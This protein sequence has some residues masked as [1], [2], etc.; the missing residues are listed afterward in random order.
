VSGPLAGI[1]VLEFAGIGPGPFA[2]MLLADLGADVVRLER[3][4]STMAAGREPR[5]DV[6]QRGKRS[7]GLDLRQPAGV[8]LALELV[9]TADAVIE[10]FR[11]GVMERL[12]VGP[13]ECLA[14]NP[15]LIFGRMTGWGQTG[16][17]AVRAGH[18]INYVALSGA[19]HA[20]G[21]SGETPVP[22]LNLVGDFGGGGLLLAFGILAALLESRE[23]GS[24]QVVDAA[25]VDGA[26][27]LTTLFY[28]MAAEGRWSEQRGT[29]MLDSGAPF[30]EVY[31]C[32]DGGF[33]AVGAIEPQFYA[34][35]LRVMDLHEAELPPESDQSAW[36]ELKERFGSVFAT[37]TRDEWIARAE[38]T[39]ACIT[40]V[41]SFGESPRH[42]HTM[43][44]DTFVE[45]GGVVQPAPAPR[46]SRTRAPTPLP[47]AGPGGGGR[48][49]LLDWGVPAGRL[50]ELARAGVAM[51]E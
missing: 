17:L 1:R 48:A 31:A 47:P 16:P 6:M 34:E 42:P 50:E 49:A 35:L 13:A 27:L 15:R 9:A 37:R 36:P 12:G 28:G 51:V 3:P 26:A 30:Y 38:G 18:D 4:P 46:F 44:R 19:L 45:V 32:A 8:E 25:M 33:V 23:S 24:G 10:G 41:L 7:F 29:N 40:P 2:G 11:P 20:I 39:D 14:R 5:F 21:R 22:P 43:A